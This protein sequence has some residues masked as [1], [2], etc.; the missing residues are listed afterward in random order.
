VISDS[1][2]GAWLG[3]DSREKHRQV[4]NFLMTQ[5]YLLLLLIS[6]QKGTKWILSVFGIY[7]FER[8]VLPLTKDKVRVESEDKIKQRQL[9]RRLINDFLLFLFTFFNRG[10]TKRFLDV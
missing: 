2:L 7:L 8:R 1:W 4:M 10:K 3:W 6:P 9:N 5:C